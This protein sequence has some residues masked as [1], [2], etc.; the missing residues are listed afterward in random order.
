MWSIRDTYAVIGVRRGG[1]LA[2]GRELVQL[3]LETVE[4]VRHFGGLRV[5]R[6]GVWC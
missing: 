4:T 1:D 5:Y 6:R 2:P 3:A